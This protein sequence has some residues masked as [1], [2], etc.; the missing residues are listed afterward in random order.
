MYTV[1]MTADNSGAEVL[2]AVMLNNDIIPALSL[3]HL[4]THCS[5][6]PIPCFYPFS[7]RLHA[8]VVVAAVKGLVYSVLQASSFKPC[9]SSIPLFLHLQTNASKIDVT[10]GGDTS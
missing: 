1:A 10:S 8:S 6:Y 9:W 7:A 4:M 5:S 2:E 3:M